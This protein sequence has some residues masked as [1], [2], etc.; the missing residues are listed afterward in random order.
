MNMRAK[1]KLS[2]H[3]KWLAGAFSAA[4]TICLSLASIVGSNHP[5]AK[6]CLVA[7]SLLIYVAASWIY[8]RGRIRHRTPLAA[9]MVVII[10]AGCVA[11]NHIEHLKTPSSTQPGSVNVQQ[12]TPGAGSVAVNG[13]GNKVNTNAAPPGTE[14]KKGEKK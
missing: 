9:L 7:F 11:W 2:Q 1:I 5:N 10:V 14:A 8:S 3:E 12:S 6:I 4:G 13:N